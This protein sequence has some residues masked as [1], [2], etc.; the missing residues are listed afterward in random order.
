MA[1]ASRAGMICELIR[2]AKSAEWIRLNVMGVRLRVFLPRLVVLLT[3][4]D[5]FHSLNT[6]RYPSLTSHLWSRSSCVLL[7]D[8]SIPSTMKRRPG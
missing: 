5:E 3:I 1:P 4:G 8:P 6:T 2:L 7:P